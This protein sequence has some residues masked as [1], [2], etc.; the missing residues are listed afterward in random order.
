MCEAGIT[1]VDMGIT[2]PGS[3]CQ[4][5]SIQDFFGF[6]IAYPNRAGKA[7]RERPAYYVIGIKMPGGQCLQTAGIVLP[8][9]SG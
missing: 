2:E 1:E 6:S 5:V 8:E 9:I 3:C 7:G 4:S